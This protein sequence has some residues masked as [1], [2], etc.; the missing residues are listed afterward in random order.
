VFEYVRGLKD[1][2]AILGKF[3]FLQ[4]LMDYEHYVPLNLPVIQSIES[5]DLS[6]LLNHWWRQH[7][8]SGLLLKQIDMS[9]DE[10]PAVR[11]QAILTLRNMLKK[12]DH[13]E[14]YQCPETRERIANLYFPFVVLVAER[15]DQLLEERE[16]GEWLACFLHIARHCSRALLRSWWQRDTQKRQVAFLRVLASSVSVPDGET[17]SLDAWATVFEL[18]PSPSMLSSLLFPFSS[19]CRSL[20]GKWATGAVMMMMTSD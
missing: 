15:T 4:I 7:F 8:L 13:D 14:R 3:K 9:R 17:P 1:Q 2:H 18:R 12:H 5:L 10:L 6:R 20:T 16:R 11:T 19:P